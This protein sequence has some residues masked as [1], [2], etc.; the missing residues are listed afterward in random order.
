MIMQPP[1][2]GIPALAA[3]I[4]P[5]L[6]A[7]IRGAWRAWAANAKRRRQHAAELSA[8]SDARARLAV[9]GGL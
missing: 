3:P 5:A 2:P 8:E 1:L 6:A 7:A 4:P 9:Q